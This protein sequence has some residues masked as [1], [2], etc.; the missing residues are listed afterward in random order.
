MLSK[1][2]GIVISYIKYRETSLIARIYTEEFGLH[3]CLINGVRNKSSKSKIALFQPLTLLDLI[4]YYKADGMSR[5]SEIRCSYPYRSLHTDARKSAIAFF[6]KE[7]L[8]KTLQEETSN[9]ELY[10]FLDHSLKILD[11]STDHYENFHLI[12]LL[13]LSSFLGFNPERLEDLMPGEW[14]LLSEEENMLYTSIL[15]SEYKS[16]IRMTN[17]TRRRFLDILLKFFSIHVSNFDRMN[18]LSVLQELMRN[19]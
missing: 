7:I 6:V 14:E 1:T 15:K 2:R 13:K 17:Q 19:Y 16:I 12:F 8:Y 11:E 5:I 9:P 4:L 18:S 10:E 3:S